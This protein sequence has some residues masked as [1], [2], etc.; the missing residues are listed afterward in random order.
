MLDSNVFSFYRDKD[1][2]KLDE[3]R[4]AEVLGQYFDEFHAG[5]LAG[6]GAQGE[7][8]SARQAFVGEHLLSQEVDPG[9]AP[10]LYG[11]KR[12]AALTPDRRRNLIGQYFDATVAPRLTGV[13]EE[14]RDDLRELYVARNM[15]LADRK[16]EFGYGSLAARTLYDLPEQ[17]GTTLE[18]AGRQALASFTDAM[19]ASG[20]REFRDG[21]DLGRRFNPISA[22]PNN[23]IN[24]D[25]RAKKRADAVREARYGHLKGDIVDPVGAADS[26][27]YSGASAVLPVAGG[28]VSGPLGVAGAAVSLPISHYAS[29]DD[30][31][32]NLV[33]QANAYAAKAGKPPLS[34][35]E[36]N[37]L[38]NEAD[39][40]ATE[41]GGWEA[42]T[43]QASNAVFGGV[44]GKVLGLGGKAAAG[45]LKGVAQK[46]GLGALDFAG[47]HVGETAAQYGQG[48]IE[49]KVGL[50][51][52]APSIAQAF[53][54]Q[55][56]ATNALFGATR[57]TALG[58]GKAGQALG[59]I[60]TRTPE[61]KGGAVDLTVDVKTTEQ[62]RPAAE[63][64]DD[65]YSVDAVNK[66]YLDAHAAP[67]PGTE[68]LTPTARPD[69]FGPSAP[70]PPPAGFQGPESFTPRGLF[71]PEVTGPEATE[72]DN[73]AQLAAEWEARQS[74]G[75]P[76]LAPFQTAADLFSAVAPYIGGP[77][78]SVDMLRPAPDAA[79]QNQAALQQEIE[80]RQAI[81]PFSG[82]FQGALPSPREFGPQAQAVDM[83]GPEALTFS[84]QQARQAMAT[85][86]YGPPQAA[87]PFQNVS[88]PDASPVGQAGPT[89]AE[90]GY[91]D[92][93]SEWRQ[94]ELDSGVKR[95]FT[96]PSYIPAALV[97]R[98]EV[99][100]KR[101]QANAKSARADAA[102]AK[103]QG[104][105]KE[106]VT[107]AEA[108]VK[109]AEAAHQEL[110]AAKA[111]A[112]EQPAA[113]GSPAQA[114]AQK[115]SETAAPATPPLEPAA[116]PRPTVLPEPRAKKVR[117]ERAAAKEASPAET[118]VPANPPLEPAAESVAADLPAK[119][120][121]SSREEKGVVSAMRDSVIE[122][123]RSAFARLRKL[124]LEDAE[125]AD[126]T[127]LQQ[128]L[129]RGDAARVFNAMSEA[130]KSESAFFH[131]SDLPR[132]YNANE[133]MAS[134][135]L[136][137][138]I[139]YVSK[140]GFLFVTPKEGTWADAKKTEERRGKD[141]KERFSLSEAE[142]GAGLPASEVQGIVD[143]I[144]KSWSGAPKILVHE[145]VQD[146][147]DAL[148]R[149]AAKEVGS[150]VVA[151]MYDG[152]AVHL[153]A[154]NLRSAKQ[155]EET[156]AE[157][158]LR[159]HGL[160]VA[161]G[162]AYEQIMNLAWSNKDVRERAVALGELYGWTEE[163]LKN[164]P[165][166]R[167]AAVDEA[168]AHMT[169]EE[170]RG[171]LF[172]R[173]VEAV[174][175]WLRGI[176]IKTNFTD[177]EVRRLIGHAA[178]A[179][180]GGERADIG[181]KV[182]AKNITFG[183]A[184]D[185]NNA[186]L[187][188]RW[189][190][191][192]FEARR[193]VTDS[194]AKEVVPQVLRALG[195]QGHLAEQ[196]GGYMENTNP[197]LALM[198]DNQADLI[199][200]AKALGHVLSQDSVV[201]VS[202]TA[203]EGLEPNGAVIIKLP[204]GYGPKE[205]ENLF[206]RLR[207]LKDADGNTMV[208]GHTTKNG[209]MGLLNFT[210]LDNEVFADIIYT[211]LDGEF[212]VDDQTVHSALINHREY[213]YESGQDAEAGRA[214][215]VQ[216]KLGD[217]QSRAA[218]LLDAAL[219]RHERGGGK[220][221]FNFRDD[222]VHRG[223]D[224]GV[225]RDAAQDGRGPASEQVPGYGKALDGAV[226]VNGIHYSKEP[227]ETLDAGKYGTGIKGAE[228]K[229]L[230]YASDDRLKSRTY[231]YVD[232]GQ[233]VRPE[234][235]VGANIHKVRL[236]NLYDAKADPKGIIDAV[237][238]DL[239]IPDSDF[240]NAWESAVI[241]AGFD[242]YYMKGAFGNMGSAVVIGPQHNAIPVAAQTSNIRFSLA[243]V[244]RPSIPAN[245]EEARRTGFFKTMRHVGKVLGQHSAKDISAL[246]K[247][248]RQAWW[249]AKENADARALLDVQ[250]SRDEEVHA[251]I[252]RGL[253]PVAE[254]VESLDAKLMPQLRGLIFKLDGKALEGVTAA[255]F[256]VDGEDAEGNA[257]LVP[258]QEHY[259]QIRKAVLDAGVAPAVAETYIAIRKSL[260]GAQHQVY[261]MMREMRLK[262][263]IIG[264]FRNQ[265]GA[266]Q[267]YF[268]HIRFGT[269]YIT[270]NDPNAA[271]GERRVVHRE[272]VDGAGPQGLARMTARVRE[273]EAKHPGMEIKFGKVEGLPEEVYDL[274]VSAANMA[275]ILDEATK[276]M[277][278][279]LRERLRDA[280]ASQVAD[281]LSKRGWAGHT[282]K[283]TDV[284]GYEVENI[285]RVLLAYHTGLQ[286]WLGKIRAAHDFAP[287]LSKMKSSETPRLYA[288]A[289]QYVRDML[290][291]RDKMDRLIS[292]T[293]TAL[294]IGF[295][296]GN[297]KSAIVNLTQNG[298]AGV[299]RLSV[300]SG[301]GRGAVQYVQDALR[302]VVYMATR[303]RSGGMMRGGEAAFLKDFYDR[304][305]T[306]ANFMAELSGA[307]DANLSTRLRG[308]V[309]VLAWPMQIA[310]RFNRTSLALAAYRIAR[311]GK[312][313]DKATLER[314]GRAKGEKFDEEQAKDFAREI[315]LDSHF[316]T[317]KANQ[318]EI[319]RGTTRAL[320]PMYTFRSFSHGLL[321]LW[322][323]L[324][325]NRG[326]RGKAAV[327]YS[328]AATATLGGLISLPLYGTIM[329]LLRQTGGDD[330]DKE[331]RDKIAQLAGKGGADVALYGIGA[332]AGDGFTI[333]GSLGMEL[334]IFAD[335][336]GDKPYLGQVLGNLSEVAGVPVAVLEKAS[337]SI[338][339]FNRGDAYRGVEEAMPTAVAN[340]MQAIRLRN[341]GATA[342]TGRPIAEFGGKEQYR[343][344]DSEAVGKALGFQP[345]SKAQAFSAKRAIEDVDSYRKTAQDRLLTRYVKARRA[346]DTEGVDDVL[347]DWREYNAKMRAEGK[348]HLLI[349]PLGKLARKRMKPEQPSKRTKA[350]TREYRES[351]GG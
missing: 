236:D 22:D 104:A 58:L 323:H 231:F 41:Y 322:R 192:S 266:I 67:F 213:G 112:E 50:R 276:G 16:S 272:H 341:E 201:V 291:N 75:R 238:R 328:L 137:D 222:R 239:N 298:I 214:G 63:P 264:K 156:L 283:R 260:D 187:T 248:L 247:K 209:E 254:A 120:V 347:Q 163:D 334:P 38:V 202:D 141:G 182:G 130:A 31:L 97:R 96:A 32:V 273:L 64:Q 7:I 122:S 40:L 180:Q 345:I 179:V 337:R 269:H 288:W 76:Q 151:G 280:V 174:N 11:D 51:D 60:D 160:R 297:L 229:R 44:L 184:P 211:H 190:S 171:R 223:G 293:R 339:F 175:R 132:V 205:I 228:H 142:G 267:N 168:I 153:V 26:A 98:A 268:P 195:V 103:A 188:G 317:G 307:L 185:P 348:T 140:R 242:G 281:T 46:V 259:D 342:A 318:P 270:V 121:G 183:V 15:T 101:A 321:S 87:A 157:E 173:I 278:E 329:G 125:T 146:L 107:Q 19:D 72:A 289:Q 86:Q 170:A 62:D 258:N 198:V 166:K 28:L 178:D 35:E 17:V 172:D 123:A 181:G 99:A 30:F 226:S 256:T 194:V 243:E 128:K 27:G 21:T 24:E 235:G 221:R 325:I 336:R 134:M 296:G 65:P 54:E 1:F 113:A 189:N 129:S 290:R 139:G 197:S 61:Q 102:I 105:P 36:V 277:G 234:P 126:K 13:D 152:E 295:L 196:V 133:F 145:T 224:G 34:Q 204:E 332:L 319:V 119:A 244:A 100:T 316:L 206:N 326:W 315:V 127:P 136:G 191:L 9:A 219:A 324:F 299:P 210:S 292:M 311:D 320:A 314:Y 262:K 349:E 257:I 106:I 249:M 117:R 95:D 303:G 218:R 14:A 18:Q 313:V 57:G 12:F 55:A 154:E 220:V 306:Q 237:A 284:P 230:S 70:P 335:L 301:L 135:D 143:N 215:S 88:F 39:D 212:V 49:A 20:A 56:P 308:I 85:P 10:V 351:L 287:I 164:D 82:L 177:A 138:H 251:N 78:R 47:E 73:Q 261:D 23:F 115:Q 81:A 84:Q 108:K 83:S 80:A 48:G 193:S 59:V 33:D 4:K 343:F 3:Q 118:A 199:P 309:N 8:A 331:L 66:R 245:E 186:E 124:S 271:E 69:D 279:D 265:M 253:R 53:K 227:R 285:G 93:A 232:E 111:D 109:A 149:A 167:I 165:R 255:K 162:D 91:M 208:D 159:H 74:A 286:G 176:G 42:L 6:A 131:G 217:L 148:T 90:V 304:G 246:E 25:I 203:M 216:R 338:S 225:P 92:V 5:D 43:E 79:A 94:R 37:A 52:E 263:D 68:S 161:L 300:E 241:D 294:F 200:A 169:S 346:G 144:S 305:L 116:E 310:E 29:K 158:V 344:T 302:T 89:P 110:L 233:G 275:Q 250:T 71:S 2:L 114:P 340:I 155:V 240:Q 147:K 333:S 330:W 77:A 327:G 274:P 350:L 252:E 45:G 282:I 207:T 150:K 312:I